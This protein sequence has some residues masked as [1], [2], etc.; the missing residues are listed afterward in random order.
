M[1]LVTAQSLLRATVFWKYQADVSPFSPRNQAD[2]LAW[3]FVPGASYNHVAHYAGMLTAGEETT[4]D[5]YTPGVVL[6]GE[7]PTCTK[8]IGFWVK[9]T[10]DSTLKIEPGDTNPLNWPFDSAGSRTLTPGGETAGW[11][12]MDGAVTVVSSTARTWKLTNTGAADIEVT[13]VAFIGT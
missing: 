7:E 8:I 2:T 6:S 12:R 9:A 3:S 10:G 13:L 5:F 1:S 11:C 4:V